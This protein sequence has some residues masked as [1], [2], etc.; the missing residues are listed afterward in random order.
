MSRKKNKCGLI[1]KD[2]LDKEQSNEL[3]SDLSKLYNCN[4][5]IFDKLLE[6]IQTRKYL[7]LKYI[8]YIEK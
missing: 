4:E 6:P 1:R 5:N 2:R 7:F 3:I 8:E